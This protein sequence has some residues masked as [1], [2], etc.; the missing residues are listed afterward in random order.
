MGFYLFI[1]FREVFMMCGRYTIV[2][3]IDE[4]M[5]HY[6]IEIPTNRYHTPR[7]NV[8][9]GQMVMAVISD[10]EK[11]RL[12]ELKW[13]LIP[14]WAKDEKIG[15]KMINARDETVDKLPSYRM[16]FRSKRCLIPADGFYEWR[17]SD[18]QPFRITLKS[19]QIFSMA[20]LY[21][22]W[23]APDGTKISSCTIITTD[24]NE[25]M[26]DIHDRMPMILSRDD[27]QKWLDR[28]QTVEDLKKMLKPFPMEEMKAYPV[29]KIVGNARNDH[30][31]CIV[32]VK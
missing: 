20:G 7:Y 10:G 19:E 16:P 17:K 14:S 2:I 4:L 22:T 29:S 13:G 32:E 6:M 1:L 26:S 21:D 27:E 11:N 9:P 8:A 3:T 31:D 30:A 18:K 15:Y 12:G 24:P 23:I 28:N 5:R 25:L